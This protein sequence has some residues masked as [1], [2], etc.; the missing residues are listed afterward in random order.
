MF[1]GLK[2]DGSNHFF[3]PSYHLFDNYEYWIVNDMEMQADEYDEQAIMFRELLVETG[4]PAM[5]S[6]ASDE[7]R[8]TVR[9]LHG[10]VIRYH[11]ARF[12]EK[13]AD[14]NLSLESCD[15]QIRHDLSAR[16]APPQWTSFS[17]LVQYP[18]AKHNYSLIHRILGRYHER[19]R[20][21]D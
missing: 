6:A 4:Q 1:S 15:G 2:T 13:G 7:V 10:N 3:L 17:Y 5:V 21:Q 18:V 19:A 14:V 9:P 11:L 20:K 16:D 8:P 12:Q